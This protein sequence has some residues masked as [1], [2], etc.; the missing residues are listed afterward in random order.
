MGGVH[1]FFMSCLCTLESFFIRN[2]CLC[3]LHEAKEGGLFFFR[4]LTERRG[5]EEEEEE[6]EEEKKGG[7]YQRVKQQYDRSDKQFVFEHFLLYL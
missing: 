1:W 3:F 4:D 6:E 7:K 5:E 2:P